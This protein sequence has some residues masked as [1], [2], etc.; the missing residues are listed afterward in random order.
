MYMICVDDADEGRTNDAVQLL[1]NLT[2]RVEGKANPKGRRLDL[3]SH[4]GEER[5]LFRVMM[6]RTSGKENSGLEEKRIKAVGRRR[7]LRIQATLD[8]IPVVVV[9]DTG[10]EGI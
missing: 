9:V 6:I 7:I 2:V 1:R 4:G 8:G 10:S 3:N 5:A